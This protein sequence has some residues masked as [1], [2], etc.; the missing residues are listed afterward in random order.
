[1]SGELRQFARINRRGVAT[2]A[3]R[4]WWMKDGADDRWASCRAAETDQPLLSSIYYLD[5]GFARLPKFG[6]VQL[7][8]CSSGKLRLSFWRISGGCSTR[9]SHTG[10]LD[11]KG[12]RYP[13]FR[14]PPAGLEGPGPSAPSRR[15]PHNRRRDVVGFPAKLLPF[16]ETTPFS[17]L[18]TPPD[19]RVWRQ[20]LAEP[21]LDL[22]Q[23]TGATVRRDGFDHGEQRGRGWLVLVHTTANTDWSNLHCRVCLWIFCVG[24]S[25]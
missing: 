8:S 12:R 9:Q 7:P 20:V 23:K 18:N 14:G 6:R 25:D 13:P 21:A 4:F 24:S 3:R 22:N 16:E 11:E 19:V 10:R 15:W 17:G 5:R 1:M 2:P